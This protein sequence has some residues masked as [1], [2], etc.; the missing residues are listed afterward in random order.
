MRSHA[1]VRTRH[2]Q[3]VPIRIGSSV[4]ERII[5]YSLTPILNPPPHVLVLQGEGL[6]AQLE[7]AKAALKAYWR[8][9]E[10]R[11]LDDVTSC[12]DMVLLQNCP[13]LIE[14][15][16]MTEVSLLSLCLL[17]RCLFSPFVHITMLEDIAQPRQHNINLSL[18]SSSFRFFSGAKLDV[19]GNLGSDIR[20]GPKEP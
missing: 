9:S 17:L 4:T 13:A 3:T 12:I 7:D 8:V 5:D 19:C 14:Q 11:L 1:V 6:G 2:F 15:A 10:A 18:L 20:S 16:L